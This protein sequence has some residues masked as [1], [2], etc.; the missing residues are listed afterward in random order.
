MTLGG[1]HPT[2]LRNESEGYIKSSSTELYLF[3]AA[4][5]CCKSS[6]FPGDVMGHC[7]WLLSQGNLTDSFSVRNRVRNKAQITCMGASKSLCRMVSIQ[8]RDGR[9]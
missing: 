1:D 6:H 5:Q 9:E 7:A 4:I 2:V 3:T 8:V